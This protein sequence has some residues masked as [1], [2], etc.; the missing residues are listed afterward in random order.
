MSEI[1][2]D[3]ARTMLS[4][5]MEADLSGALAASKAAGQPW[6]VLGNASPIARMLVPDVAAL[7]IDP[8]RNRN[9]DQFGKGPDLLW[10]GKW[11]LPFYTDTW[12]GYPAARERLYGL[13]QAQGVRDLLVLTGDSHSFWMNTL[14]DAAGLPMGL[15]LG[16][17]GITSPGDFVESGWDQETATR[18]DRLFEQELPEVVWTDNL[19]QGY[20]RVTLTHNGARADFVAVDTVLVPEF[21]AFVLRST[22]IARQGETLVYSEPA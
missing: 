16:T 14:A 20:V 6:R 11:N 17:A 15:E 19:H 9:P 4:P 13:A 5:E 3:L 18:L 8:S 21:R 2:G 10:T 7:G 22:G 1:I 12:D